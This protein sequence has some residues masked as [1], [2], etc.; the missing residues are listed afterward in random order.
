MLKEKENLIEFYTDGATVGRNG[1]L[2][3]V[4]H[5]GLGVYCPDLNLRM[6]KIVDGISNNEA[7]FKALIWAM[8]TAITL[9]YRNVDFFSDSQ[10]IVNRA[11]GRRPSKSKYTNLRMDNFQDKVF[12]LRKWFR[13]IRFAWI[14]REH[15]AIADSLSGEK[16]PNNYRRHS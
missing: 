7:E 3:T 15:N 13:H 10:I 14:P 12:E 6:S 4:T 1:K 11:N 2:G 8:E 5:V 16:I 9:C